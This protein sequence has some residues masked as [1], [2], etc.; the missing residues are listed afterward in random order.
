MEVKF[1]RAAADDAEALVNVRNKSFYVDFVKY[2]ECPGYNKSIESMKSSILNRIAYKIIC[3]GQI[4][5]NI[6]LRDNSDNTYYLGCLCVIPEYENKGVGQKALRFIES[7]FPDAACWTLE[8]PSDKEK[9]LYF[10]K[11]MGY[12]IAH[13]YMHG[14][15]KVVQ[16]EKKIKPR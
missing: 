11:E 9:N 10:Y 13:E 2:G 14:L 16:L 4:V 6:S 3:N 15:V 7:Q 12:A 1:E 8:T 5:G